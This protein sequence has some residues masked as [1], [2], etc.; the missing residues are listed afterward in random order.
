MGDLAVT[1]RFLE[2]QGQRHF[3]SVPIFDKANLLYCIVER[4]L[5]TAR[6]TG[7]GLMRSVYGSERCSVVVQP[8]RTFH[9]DIF[10]FLASSDCNKFMIFDHSVAGH[11]HMNRMACSLGTLK[12]SARKR[13]L[14][15]TS[16]TPSTWHRLLLG[17]HIRIY[18]T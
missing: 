8:E 7:K 13:F 6:R 1:S 2:R 17:M 14:S 18:H 4:T 11:Q 15:S 16:D 12:K 5:R 9:L 10:L 3:T